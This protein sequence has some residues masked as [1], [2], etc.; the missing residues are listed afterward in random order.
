VSEFNN[1][2]REN[3]EKPP[4]Q[5]KSVIVKG[6][7]DPS[8]LNDMLQLLARNQIRYGAA[9]NTGRKYKGFD[10]LANAG[11]EVTIE[12]GD[13]LI[14]AFQPESRFMQ[15][16]FEPD[17]KST[18]SL[19]YDLTAWALPYAY[20]LKAY[21]LTEK[22]E[23]VDTKE[24]VSPVAALPAGNR[25]YAYLINFT[26]FN[27]FRYLSAI[28]KKGLKARYSMKPFSIDN[29]TFERGSL[30][31]AH[32]D[33][34]NNEKKFDSVVREEAARLKVRITP[35]SSGHVD[36]GKDF[37]SDYS[38]L[39]R[40]PEIAILCGNR[41]PSGTVGELWYFFERELEYP[42]TLINTSNLESI[43]LRKYNT[44]ILGGGNFT[45]LKD[46]IF[47]FARK[48]GRVIALESAISLFSSDKSTLLFKAVE[49]RN[50]EQKTADKKVKSDDTSLLRKYEDRERIPLSDRSAGSIYRVR[51]DTTNPFGF[52]LGYDWFIMKHS[53]IFPFIAGGSNVGYIL[54]KEPVSG[55]A[56]YKFKNKIKNTLVIGSE[57][58]GSG[59]VI[60][61]VDDPYFRAFWK[62]GRIL[63]GNAIFR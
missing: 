20:N 2:F 42:V 23:P 34:M 19:S 44:V 40:K 32:G 22:I 3:A 17:S 18:D 10:Y 9:G 29:T 35:V 6:S 62:S 28:L 59:E 1:F 11:G 46:T 12:K 24:E 36:K 53:Q 39:I 48:G 30:I 47:D 4:F 27:E 26:G 54:E 7:N 15:V 63:L 61:I 60:Y 25:P 41:V 50:E 51:I 38:P 52:G 33:N 45:G 31:I 43:D 56:G 21:A 58:I 55:F 5:Y 57:R 37:G 13:I 49:M 14:S 8:A 16:L